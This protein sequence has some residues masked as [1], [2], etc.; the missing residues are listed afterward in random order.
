MPDDVPEEMRQYFANLGP[1]SWHLKQFREGFIAGMEG[2]FYLARLDG[3]FVG[4]VTIFSNGAFGSL[5]HV[6]TVPDSRRLG[7]ARALLDAA[8]ADFEQDSGQ[9]LV[10][11]TKFNGFKWRLYNSVGFAGIGVQ[12]Q[13]DW[14]VKFFSGAD[15]PD[16]FNC[17][18]SEIRPLDWRHFVGVQL[19]FG[20]PGRQQIR[21][22]HLPCMGRRFVEMELLRFKRQASGA[23]VI[24]GQGPCVGGFAAVRRH[25][26]WGELGERKV[27]DLFV[28][29]SGSHMSRPLLE[30]VL[31]NTSGP[32][33][34]YCDC[35]A[36]RKIALLKDSG[37]QENRIRS[38]FNIGGQLLDLVLMVNEV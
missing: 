23:W 26:M 18:S 16:M 31:A 30:T 25:P 4:N 2:K 5:W 29:N 11:S 36:E 22:I 9:V 15:W 24:Q 12:D 37:F 19:L 28:H 6:Y 38:T 1:W 33:E 20:S 10:L 13:H 7:V 3:R 21:S 32:L 34:C 14:M 17:Q 8:I 35:T 27:L